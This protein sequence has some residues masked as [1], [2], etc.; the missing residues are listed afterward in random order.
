[1]GQGRRGQGLFGVAVLVPTAVSA[2]YI[3][4]AAVSKIKANN[5]IIVLA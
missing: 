4:N 3:L 5:R 2:M 1:V